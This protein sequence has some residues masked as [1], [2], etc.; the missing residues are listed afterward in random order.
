MAGLPPG[1]EEIAV[2]FAGLPE[3]QRRDALM[4]CADEIGLHHPVEGEFYAIIDERVDPGCIDVVALY[5]RLDQDGRVVCRA[6]CGPRVRTLTRALVTIL[7]RGLRG[8]T[9]RQVAELGD[10]FVV[11]IVGE[12]LMRLRSRSVYQVLGRMRDAGR[13][14]EAGLFP[15]DR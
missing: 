10:D 1:L 7:C 11:C 8:A 4:A 9:P 2:L 14:L 5:F 3:A 6:R 13:Q 12:P 15:P